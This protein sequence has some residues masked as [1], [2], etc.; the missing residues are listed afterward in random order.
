MR[1]DC[2]LF[3]ADGTLLDFDRSEEQSLRQM[4]ADFGIA[5]TPQIAERY[6]RINLALWKALERGEVSKEE[7]QSRRFAALFQEF[8][9]TAN[10][11]EA[12]RRY[13]A[14]LSESGLLLPGAEEVCRAL[15]AKLPL[16]IVT[17]GVGATQR[18]RMAKSGI[19][20]CFGA[21]FI[22]EEIGV[23]KPH[24]AYFDVVLSKIGATDCRRVLL[25][26]DSLTSD[27]QGGINANL[28][29]CWY[30]PIRQP[31]PRQMNIDLEITALTELYGY[32]E[33]WS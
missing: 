28:C 25:V 27:M 31:V 14:Y 30:N 7:L 3:D 16:Y 1:F 20:D 11:N 19:A 8:G 10:G 21:L 23:P 32:I 6:Q 13:L 17:N 12:N 9:L 22:S 33:D 4:L 26:G 2:I 15:A 24:K 29:T 18:K 5:C